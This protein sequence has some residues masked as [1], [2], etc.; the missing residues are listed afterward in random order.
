MTTS[1]WLFSRFVIRVES[2]NGGGR[3]SG[4]WVRQLLYLVLLYIGFCFLSS[5]KFPDGLRVCFMARH[6][7]NRSEPPPPDLF[8]GINDDGSIWNQT[9]EKRDVLTKWFRRFSVFRRECWKCFIHKETE[10]TKE[11]SDRFPSFVLFHFICTR[12]EKGNDGQCL[13]FSEI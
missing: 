8:I 5:L 4:D 2:L 6:A 13:L 9:N 12:E 3:I 7:P 1:D 11:K 10:Q